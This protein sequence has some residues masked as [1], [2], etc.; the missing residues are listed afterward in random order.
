MALEVKARFSNGS[1]ADY[2]PGQVLTGL[3]AETEAYLLRAS[4]G[5]FA[6]IVPNE[7]NEPAVQPTVDDVTEP[8]D[9]ETVVKDIS[10]IASVAT[11]E[12][13]IQHRAVVRRG[14]NG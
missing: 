5:S 8:G 12:E 11:I 9:S 13:P 14:R 3:D 7:P 1:W 2:F 6:R 10:S 4:P